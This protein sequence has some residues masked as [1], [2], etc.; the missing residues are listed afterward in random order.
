MSLEGKVALVTGDDP[1]TTAFVEEHLD[2][3]PRGR[4]GRPPVGVRR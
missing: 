2:F 1:E 4:A 3:P